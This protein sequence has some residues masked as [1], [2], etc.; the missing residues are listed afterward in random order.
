MKKFRVFELPRPIGDDVSGFARRALPS[1]DQ[2]RDQPVYGWVNPSC[3]AA[4]DIA[5]E[6]CL[7]RNYLRMILVRAEKC[8]PSAL[9]KAE[10][11]MEETLRLKIS[12]NDYLSRSER[13][14]IRRE[15]MDRMLP[16]MPVSLRGVEFAAIPEGTRLFA[17]CSSDAQADVLVSF[18]REATGVTAM[19]WSARGL[20][21]L[22]GRD[23][24]GW[25]AMTFSGQVDADRTAHHAGCD[26]LTWLW[27]QSET[28]CGRVNAGPSGFIGILLEGPLTLVMEGGGTHVTRLAKGNPVGSVEAKSCLQAGKK[29]LKAKLTFVRGEHIWSFFFDAETFAVS[30]LRYA[31][32]EGLLDARSRFEYDMDQTEKVARMIHGLFSQFINRIEAADAVLMRDW[33]D[34]RNVSI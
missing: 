10:I 7:M 13:V 19:P 33:V 23:P 21:C 6:H 29:L 3:F 15:I 27:Y 17:T 34:A 24:K 18:L 4:R 26:F 8:I 20:L 12:G 22:C 31:Y 9:L 25:P 5:P 2:V 32:P 11:K 16:E 28:F 14:E 30:G 1:F